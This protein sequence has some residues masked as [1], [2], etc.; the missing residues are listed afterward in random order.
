[1]LISAVLTLT[2]TQ[3]V[4]LPANLGRA[5]HA[6]FLDQVR[7]ADPAI[8]QAL[9]TPNQERP[10]TVSNLWGTGQPTQ[11]QVTLA[12]ER[13]CC[14]RVTSFWPELSALVQERM[15]PGL[16]ETVE[17]AGAAF[18]LAGVTTDGATH[19]WAGKT[20]FEDL[21]QQHTLSPA[22]P[23]AGVALRFAS[24]T[25][26]RSSGVN[27]PLPLP[28]LVFE[29]LARRWNAFAPIHIHP[30]V[31]RFADE[32]LVITRY[33]LQTE[34]VTFGEEGE[35]GAY[36]GFVGVCG[37]GFQVKDRYWMGLIHLLAAFALYAGVGTRTT[38]GL[39]QARVIS[40]QS[41]V[42]SRQSPVHSPKYAVQD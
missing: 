35:R 40:R 16:P 3:P 34:R 1:M 29:G 33:Q 13:P 27:V 39:G 19:P 7:A 14:L 18:R 28:G 9:H 5:T 36:P 21:V 25:V 23:P 17:L 37:Y 8:A 6:W 12:P 15:L 38:M 11:G 31:R 22:P 32:C 4:T 42:L 41:P 10:F 24:P 26:F 20:R 30:E 2:P